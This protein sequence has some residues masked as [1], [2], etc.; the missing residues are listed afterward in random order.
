[1]EV[2]PMKA[3]NNIVKILTALAAVA[4]AVYLI[5]TYGDKLVAWAKGLLGKCSCCCGNCECE[6][7]CAE[8][9]AP[10]EEEAAPA[11]EEAPVEEEV[12]AEE[13]PV[14]EVVIEENEPVADEADFE[15]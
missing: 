2:Y 1:M 13:A 14:E 5:A 11:E 7:E 6:C 12:P 9:A 3:L 10:V 4:G 15:A 8:E